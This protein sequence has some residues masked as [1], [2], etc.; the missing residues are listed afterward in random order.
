M[1]AD[2][3]DEE[4]EQGYGI[5]PENQETVKLFCLLGAKRWRLVVT[6][7]KVSFQGLDLPSVESF[8][9]MMKVRDHKSMLEGLL[10]MEEAALPVLNKGS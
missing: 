9:R 3:E 4:D 8:L 6:M 2:D 1:F 7:E 5:W 10:V